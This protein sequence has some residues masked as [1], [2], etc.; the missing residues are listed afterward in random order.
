MSYAV[1]TTPAIIL[2]IIPAG[3]ANCDVVVFT[4]DLGK[5]TVRV[6][7]ARK[8]ESKMR[9]FLT[10][11]RKVTIDVVRGKMMWRLIGITGSYQSSLISAPS[12]MKPVYRMFRLAE[13]LIQGETPQPELFSFFEQVIDYSGIKLSASEISTLEMHGFEVFNVMSLLARLGYWDEPLENNFPNP[14]ELIR[15]GKNK[16]ELVK[17]I[18][19]SISATQIMVY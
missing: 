3:E 7:S 4:R 16:K 10:R 13:F 2:R 1:H 9:M 11:F 12:I 6:Q 14:D 17:K 15:Y 8:A 18:N 5:I 19:H